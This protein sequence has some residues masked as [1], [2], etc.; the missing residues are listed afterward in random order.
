MLWG[1]QIDYASLSDIGVRRTNNQDNFTVV[2]ETD[3]NAWEAYGHLF[4]VADGMGGHAVG[5]LASKI[6]VDTLPLS[7]KKSRDA[8]ISEALRKA[9]QATNLAIHERGTLNQEFLRMGTTCSSLVLGPEGALVGHVGDSRIYRIRNGQIDQ[10]TFDHSLQWE[11]L[12][13]G[14]GTPEEIFLYQPKNVITRSMGPEA[15]VE[16]D[17][18]GPYPVFPGDTFLLCSD[19]LSNHVNDD[20]LGTAAAELPPADACRF[21]VNLA[22]IRGGSDNIT[23]TIARVGPIPE[24]AMPSQVRRDDASSESAAL[25]L[26]AAW[27]IAAF[28]CLGVILMLIGKLIGGAVIA[29]LAVIAAI[30]LWTK[31]RKSLP[32]PPLNDHSHSTIMWRPYRSAPAKINRTFLNQV[33]EIQTRLLQI[34]DDEE[35]TYDKTEYQKLVAEAKTALSSK[36]YRQAFHL[37]AKL[38]NTLMSGLPNGGPGSKKQSRFFRS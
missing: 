20:E 37:F 23:V 31:W 16:V 5:E 9:M 4:V 34:A 38:I 1:Q 28:F 14:Q 17:L 13:R 26:G 24:G 33:I 7:Y 35:W 8:T 27:G 6:A 12:R 10:L 18:E 19:G 32:P 15:N 29:A 2:I 21:L 22:N 25:W 36:N 30:V 3:R 11:L